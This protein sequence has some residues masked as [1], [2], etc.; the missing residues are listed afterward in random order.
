MGE[1]VRPELVRI[2]KK[3]KKGQRLLW[4]SRKEFPSGMGCLGFTWKGQVSFKSSKKQAREALN[5]LSEKRCLY[6]M[7]SGQLSY[8][9]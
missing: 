3:E 8:K 1:S 7:W 9:P 5:Q 6:Q 2:K 4:N